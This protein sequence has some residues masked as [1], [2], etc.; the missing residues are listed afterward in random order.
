MD[1]AS[2]EFENP[3][4][5]VAG[6]PVRLA[7]LVELSAQPPEE[8]EALL[9]LSSY[10]RGIMVAAAQGAEALGGEGTHR[11]LRLGDILRIMLLQRGNRPF[12]GFKAFY[13]A[14]NGAAVP[15]IPKIRPINIRAK[16]DPNAIEDV[17]VGGDVTTVLAKAAELAAEL[18]NGRR[19]VVGLRHFTLALLL[20]VEGREVLWWDSLVE[21]EP[22]GVL[23][24]LSAAL[25]GCLEPQ[26]FFTDNLQAWQTFLVEA[27]EAEPEPLLPRPLQISEDSYVPDQPVGRLEQDRLGFAEEVKALARVVSLKEPGPPLAVG[28]FGDWGSGKSS[29]MNMLEDAIEQTA[30]LARE[31]E[32]AGELFVG[33]VVHIRFNAWVYNDTDL[34][35]SLTSECFRQLRRGGSKGQQKEALKSVLDKLSTFVSSALVEADSA[36]SELKGKES[37]RDSLKEDLERQEQRRAVTRAESLAEAARVTFDE[38][39]AGPVKT[40]L[41]AAG[42]DLGALED[43]ASG[44][45]A[46]SALKQ[47]VDHLAG[48]GGQAALFLMTLVRNLSFGEKTSWRVW[49]PILAGIA[50]LFLLNLDAVNAW[51]DSGLS[52]LGS[53]LLTALAALGPLAVVFRTL[54]PLFRA[55]SRFRK[56]FA[57]AEAQAEIQLADTRD[58]LE[59]AEAEVAAL[60]AKRDRAEEK[61][62][63][64]R[65]AEPS[66]LLEFFL[67]E[68]DDTRSFEANLGVV[69]KVREVFEKLEAIIQ[70][71]RER[72]AAPIDRI[73]LYIDDLDRCRAET[74]V[75][76]L[77]AVH[78]LLALKL[79]VVVVGVDQRWLSRALE[80][81]LH[82]KAPK[83]GATTTATPKDYLEKIFQIPIRLGRLQTASEA[84]GAYVESISGPRAQAESAPDAPPPGNEGAGKGPRLTIEPAEVALP[85]LEREAEESAEAVLLREHELALTKA[86]G[87]MMGRS[88]RAVK[89]FVN[90]YRLLRGMRRG[91]ALE[92]FLDPPQEVAEEGVGNYAAVQFWLAADCGMSSAQVRALRQAVHNTHTKAGLTEVFARPLPE[93]R[94][95]G[96]AKETAAIA[97]RLRADKEARPEI[98]AFWAEVPAAQSDDL[99]NAFEAIDEALPKPFAIHALRAAMAETQRFSASL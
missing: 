73:V 71:G 22:E 30:E 38:L 60:A 43:D 97:A 61:A 17:I 83:A 51:L 41:Q 49:L 75:S 88:P 25:E 99:W 11:G 95:S 26:S 35:S 19:G 32:A 84:F 7:H 63:R 98:Y 50:G 74:V 27:G 18:R 10:L 8:T 23:P 16:I 79:F 70:E 82:L 47:E 57:E 9:V 62:G 90:L 36:A 93:A 28:L 40:A 64:F 91:S 24:S 45:K 46:V 52:H 53:A 89:K 72:G 31:N 20:T 15:P 29:F 80:E 12:T 14:M 5:S 68:A 4:K 21:G 34:W 58:K 55:S 76:V 48:F 87:P 77:E 59:A 92:S 2:S 44:E 6:A 94:N 96:G 81:R 54:E 33:K 67:Q 78:L 13:N 56:T 65:E 42:S 3:L 37:E 1:A 86:L 66:D 69:S 39:G 85:P